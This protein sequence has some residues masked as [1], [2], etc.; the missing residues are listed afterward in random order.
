MSRQPNPGAG[1]RTPSGAA[2][3]ASAPTPSSPLPPSR[4]RA[5][6][7]RYNALLTALYERS[8]L[9][10]REIGAA[11][12]RTERAMQ[13]RVRALG[14]R[15]RDATK[16]RPGT[17]IGVRRPG[18]RPPLLNAPAVQRTV[19]AFA[20]VARELAASAEA[21]MDFDADRATARA[22]RLTA[23]TQTR[24]MASAAREL[25]HLAVVM[26]HASAARHA[27]AAG[28]KRK[29]GD[30][31]AGKAGSA[32]YGP[33][34]T[35]RSREEMRDAQARVLREQEMR[36]H[37][38]HKAAHAI[39]AAAAKTPVR[40]PDQRIN[41]IAERYYAERNGPRVRGL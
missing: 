34:P 36:M 9:T 23:R 27:L 22:A 28:A 21:R 10:L 3:H 41:E 38:M 25:G 14:C 15:P 16:C 1:D 19:A 8:T 18:A 11:A 24:V 20:D 5:L 4:Y 39:P 13:V 33:A 26:E 35:R 7:A 2:A 30:S 37:E 31:R 32:Q 29:S 40:D 6:R 12:G 17:T